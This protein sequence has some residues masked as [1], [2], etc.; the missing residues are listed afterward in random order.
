MINLEKFKITDYIAIESKNEIDS[1]NQ[2]V[3]DLLAEGWIPF[4]A[5]SCGGGASTHYAQSMVKIE[6]ISK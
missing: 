3:N 6:P 1:L 2:E 4:G 5:I